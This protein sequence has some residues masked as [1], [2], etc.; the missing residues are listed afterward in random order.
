[1]TWG[2]RGVLLI[3]WFIIGC[4]NF[5]GQFWLLGSI[6][7]GSPRATT[8]CEGYDRVGNIL[9]GQGNETISSYYGKK[10]GWQEKFINWLFLKLTGEANHCKNHIGK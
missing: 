10:G 7:A 2:E 1:M 4:C 3:F 9:M 8:I 5:V 6:I